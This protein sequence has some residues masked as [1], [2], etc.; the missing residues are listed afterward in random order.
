MGRVISQHVEAIQCEL[1]SCPRR[2]PITPHTV[3]SDWFD[4][5]SELGRLVRSGWALVLKERMRTYCPDHAAR[6]RECSCKR[7][8]EAAAH[9]PVHNPELA[10]F[11]WDATQTP[12]LTNS[13]LPI[14]D[15]VKESA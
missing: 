11:V 14:R 5:A 13:T 9:C 3:D 15:A 6:A 10:R 8:P 7:H 4:M 12:G 1:R 2:E